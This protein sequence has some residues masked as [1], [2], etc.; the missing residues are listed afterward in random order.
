M[1]GV[2]SS[3]PR[4][5]PA[6]PGCVSLHHLKLRA[7]IVLTSLT[8]VSVTS[9]S[10]D[11]IVFGP[12]TYSGNGRPVLDARRFRIADPSGTFVLRV[13]NRGVTDAFIALN[14][15]IVLWPS[16]FRIGVESTGFGARQDGVGRPGSGQNQREERWEPE[17][18]RLRRDRRTDRER[19]Q[20][21]GFV[22]LIER[23]VMV[24]AGNNDFVI[25]FW[26]PRGTSLTVEIVR[27]DP[28]GGDTT[29]PTI[30][31]TASPAPNA[32][33]WNN[34]PVTVSFS[35]TD[36]GSG[37][38]TCPAPVV[39]SADGAGQV[40]SRTAVD[41]AGNSATTSVTLS[42]DQTPPVV[43]ASASPG[44][45]VNGWNNGPVTVTFAAADALSGVAPGSL[46]APVTLA[47]DGVNLSAS[48][49]ATDLAGNVA[50][51]TSASVNVD[52]TPPTIELTLSPLAGPGG[53]FNGP[54]T[55]HFE[56]ADQLS[57]VS[58]CPPDQL[59]TTPGANQTVTGT[60][61]DRAGNSVSVTSDPFTI[62][63]GTP[64]ILGPEGGIISAADGR[65]IL[66]APAGAVSAPITITVNPVTSYPEPERIV[67]GTVFDFGP[68]GTEFA[69]PVQLTI[70]YDVNSIPTGIAENDL[71]LLNQIGDTWIEVEGS[72]EDV[73]M[74]TVTGAISHFTT[75]GLGLPGLPPG[76]FPSLCPDPEQT[77]APECADLYVEFCTT[78]LDDEEFD[79]RPNR[80]QWCEV[81]EDEELWIQEYR[82]Q[83][84]LPPDSTPPNASG[85]VHV[86]TPDGLAYDFQG[87]GEYLFVAAA[88]SSVVVQVRMEPWGSSLASVN[89][90][91]VMNVDGDRVG[92]YVGR[93]PELYVNGQPTEM[94]GG[95]VDLVNGG[96]IWRQLDASSRTD[97]VVEWPNG[98]VASAKLRSGYMD[99]GVSKPEG[100]QVSFAGLVGNLN[101]QAADDIR[102]RDGVTLGFPVLFDELYRSF[103][104]SWRISASESLF[105]YEPGTSTETFQLYDFPV[106]QV[107]TVD[108]DQAIVDAARQSCEAAGIQDPTLLDDCILDLA[109]TG[110]QEFVESAVGSEPPT[111]PVRVVGVVNG[112]FDLDANG[113]FWDNIDAAGGWFSTGGNPGGH[114]ALN[115]AG[116]LATDPTVCQVVEGIEIGLS[117]RI[118]GEYASYAPQFGDPARPDAFAVTVDGVVVLALPR[119][120]PVS[121][122]WTAFSTDIV[123]GVANPTICFVAERNGDD[124]SFFVDN[125]ALKGTM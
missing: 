13:T 47:T 1:L 64:T 123:S 90:A 66:N 28:A 105:D 14:G 73:H 75:F 15:R 5:Q 82:Q 69:I 70:Q 80:P 94:A 42:I 38:A 104:D 11:T 46:T 83:H 88:D 31:A 45:N 24:R 115:Q 36:S 7:L 8:L 29:P 93:S 54:V 74:K 10:A 32:G 59:V 3:P 118:T 113:W 23:E 52:T 62:F 33:G 71:R 110:Q 34:T 41:V 68:D 12:R 63:L 116:Q 103:G 95:T 61:V 84:N 86:R 72:T 117:F 51:G 111:T 2:V 92:V 98:F 37:I 85:D 112:G 78:Y 77:H 55:A 44:A 25:G 101:S 100:L 22:P 99:V 40:V 43:S 58:M 26:S 119:P 48:G 6:R 18:D 102:T 49:Q 97:Y 27:K 107:S 57:G 89:T 21:L 121:T 50:A 16:D 39:V 19:G 30:T 17:W 87:A 67:A 120:S 56:C 108:F 20:G 106:R 114:F 96:R 81:G 9:F 109:V 76:S 79:P 53:V 4:L 65:V 91:V 60:T 35:C 124:S 122:A 125:I